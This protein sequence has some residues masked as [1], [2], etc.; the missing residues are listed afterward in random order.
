MKIT[1]KHGAPEARIWDGSVE[2][3]FEIARWIV[4]KAGVNDDGSPAERIES[5]RLGNPLADARVGLPTLT[6]ETEREEFEIER[7]G[8]LV[9][10]ASQDY[11][12]DM[13]FESFDAADFARAFNVTEG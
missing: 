1:R 6:I 5:I 4:E 12:T 11:P 13:R 2:S 7:D 10:E 8:A 9:C 3:A